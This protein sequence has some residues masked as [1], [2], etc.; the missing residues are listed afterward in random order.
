MKRTSLVVLSLLCG[1]LPAAAR[2]KV[3]VHDASLPLFWIDRGFN[4]IR[5]LDD[6]T[7]TREVRIAERALGQSIVTRDALDAHANIE[8]T[9]KFYEQYF[10]REGYDGRGGRIDVAVRANAYLPSAVDIV[11]W[12]ENAF[13]NNSARVFFFGSGDRSFKSFSSALEVVAHEFT[14]A[15]I[16][17]TSRLKYVGQ[18]G[19][20]NEHFA[21][22]FGIYVRHE[23]QPNIAEP[24]LIGQTILRRRPSNGARALRDMKHPELG[25]S[26]QPTQMSEIP[27]QF[28]DACDPKEADDNCGVHILSGIPNRAAVLLIERIGWDDA[29]PLFYDVMTSRL[30]R[31]SKFADYRRAMTESCAALYADTRCDAVADSF[32]DVGILAE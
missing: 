20:L 2:S 3:Y 1:A 22:V 7:P 30:T 19:A 21:D 23:F 8:L 28:G 18:S 24:Y 16:D 10:G 29:R 27:A 31:T 32:A 25:L 5:V 17:G 12:K 4:G 26:P 14:H 15:V 11:G 9:Q 13:W 6:G